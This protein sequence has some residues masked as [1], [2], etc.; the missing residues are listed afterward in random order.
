M[1]EAID[2]PRAE[3]AEGECGRV[4]FDPGRVSGNLGF[5][6][7]SRSRVKADSSAMHRYAVLGNFKVKV[8]SLKEPRIIS[9]KPV[10]TTIPTPVKLAFEHFATTAASPRWQGCF[11]RAQESAR[12]V[13]I[14]IISEPKF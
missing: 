13:I 10:F 3:A 2:S 7:N 11:I 6:G 12:L 8:S 14:F 5:H 4:I 9:I 1:A